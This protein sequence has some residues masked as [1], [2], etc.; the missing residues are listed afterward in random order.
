MNA[1]TATINP[2]T[3]PRANEPTT[4]PTTACHVVFAAG[5]HGE[6]TEQSHGVAQA[7]QPACP[8]TAP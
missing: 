1:T 6:G 8:T 5:S 3:R 7:T 4:T 2:A